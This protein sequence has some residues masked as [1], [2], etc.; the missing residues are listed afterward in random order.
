MAV[1]PKRE[2]VMGSGE[3]RLEVAKQG[4]EP[5]EGRGL[6]TR[7]AL[8]A[9]DGVVREA[10]SAQHLETEQAI[11]GDGRAGRQGFRGPRGEPLERESGHRVEAHP[12]RAPVAHLDRRH[13]RH[14]VLRAASGLAAGTLAAEVGVVDAHIPG[15]R[16]GRFALVHSFHQ[17][18]MQQPG[19]FP[20][21]PDLASERQGRNLRLRLGHQVDRQK[22]LRHRQAAVIQ[23][24]ARGERTL[25]P[26]GAAL[27]VAT[28]IPP[29]G[30]GR[31]ATTRRAPKAARPTCLDQRRFTLCFRS[32]APKE[33]TQRKPFLELNS[34]DCHGRISRVVD[35][36]QLG[37][38][39]AHWMSLAEIGT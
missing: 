5:L 25:V 7:L 28:C 37:A 13:E 4:I 16:L 19:R 22:P 39:E 10:E 18:V 35:G 9:E 36:N 14:L 2:G 34:I 8:A 24:G 12:L 1:L 27:P 20:G 11:R 30:T 32:V 3:R 6:A 15:K 31:L 38:P 26:A 29:E 17:L 33:I 23:Q 21:H